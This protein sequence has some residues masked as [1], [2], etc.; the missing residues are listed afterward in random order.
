MDGTNPTKV[1]P[2][3]EIMKQTHTMFKGVAIDASI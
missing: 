3:R 1:I 2:N